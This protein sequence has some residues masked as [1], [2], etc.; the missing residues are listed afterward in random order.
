VTT[1]DNG[2]EVVRVP[3]ER[4]I[5][6]DKVTDTQLRVATAGDG[7]QTLQ[8]VRIKGELVAHRLIAD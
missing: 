6:N 7:T 3:C 1:S 2:K 5:L 8:S 4:E